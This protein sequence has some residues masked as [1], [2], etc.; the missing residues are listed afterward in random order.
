MF[1]FLRRKIGPLGA[2]KMLNS[3]VKI[4]FASV[5]MGFGAKLIFETLTLVIH[6][7]IAL[8]LSI[9]AGT[10]IYFVTVLFSKID[11]VSFMVEELKK[12]FRKTDAAVEQGKI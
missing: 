12:K 9:A 5:V 6:Q 10:A 1:Y 3:F 7:D 11:D 8:L 2:K 4:G